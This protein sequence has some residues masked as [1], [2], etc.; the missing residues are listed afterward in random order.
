L[1]T[2]RSS[3]IAAALRAGRIGLAV[4]AI[5]APPK[6]ARAES[7]ALAEGAPAAE[8][9]IDVNARTVIT[10]Q[11][12]KTRPGDD[13]AWASPGWPDQDWE[14]AEK[15]GTL[16]LESGYA[17]KGIRWYR[18]R[19][20]V[21]SETDSLDP[22]YFYAFQ[23]PNAQEMYWDGELVG[24]NGRVGSN[25]QEE[26]SGRIFTSI[27]LPW[28]ATR[29]G[30]H[31][32]AMRISNQIQF[33]GGIGDF[34]I[35]TWK[36]LQNAFHGPLAMMVFLVGIFFIAG[37]Y[38]FANFLNRIQPTYALFSLFCLGCSLETLPIAAAAYNNVVMDTFLWAVAVQTLG[39][40]VMMTSLPLFFLSEF[41]SLSRKWYLAVGL[42]VA[43]ITVPQILVLFLGMPAGLFKVVSKANDI[44]GFTAIAVS[45]GVTGWGVYRKQEGS[46]M[47]SL[48]LV[49]LLAGVAWG[50]IF[51]LNYAWAL[52][53]TALILFLNAGLTRRLTRQSMAYQENHLKGARLEIE[54][55]KKNIQPHF[56]LTSLR[57]ITDWLEKEPKMAARLVNALATELRMMLKLSSERSIPLPEEIKLCRTHL[58]VMGLR[59]HRVLVL[60]THGIGGEELI[61]PMVMHT[62]LE[63]G[64][65]EAEDGDGEIRFLLERR[66]GDGLILRLS[67]ASPLKPRWQRGI[68]DTGLKYVRARLEEAFPKRWSLRAGAAAT[69]SSG[70]TWQADVHI[71]DS[72]SLAGAHSPLASRSGASASG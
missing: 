64:L 4:L 56:L 27:R 49:C 72:A 69:P 58:E 28:K 62:L 65:E 35:G 66:L 51:R 67:H 1:K 6:A 47:A 39:W 5:L 23:N 25:A 3:G 37:V 10:L 44:L 2:H 18:T 50:E 38:Y 59:R 53:L 36:P 45:L 61:P 8:Y 43:L 52:G 24:V 68:D 48:G 16:W 29:P 70:S 14:R 17:V 26:K 42:V 15:A 63:M 34:K 31:V 19:I 54:L 60:D 9:A 22:L 71:S 32:L 41:S 55:L 40:S 13:A 7:G 46:L 30:T 11:K 33:S 57:S 20:E 12:W 21:A